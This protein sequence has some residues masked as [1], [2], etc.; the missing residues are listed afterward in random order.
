LIV[1]IIQYII[2]LH[3]TFLNIQKYIKNILKMSFYVKKNYAYASTIPKKSEE[4]KPTPEVLDDKTIIVNEIYNL[5]KYIDEGMRNLKN[6]L[7]EDLKN[8]LT[9]YSK[10]LS[11]MIDN[12]KD[13]IKEK[14]KGEL[15]IKTCFLNINSNVSN[16]E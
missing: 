7:K 15:E 11:L 3:K 13:E 12:L 5:K 4:V 8:D 2:I 14:N 9:E 6:E 16:D 1:K 10:E